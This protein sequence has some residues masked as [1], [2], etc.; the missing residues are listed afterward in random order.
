MRSEADRAGSSRFI[1]ASIFRV[2][3]NVPAWGSEYTGQAVAVVCRRGHKL[4]QGL[5]AWLRHS[6]ARAEYLEDG[7][8][9]WA[10]AGSLLVQT[11]PMPAR[12]MQ[13]Q[14]VWVARALLKIDRIACP[15]LIRRFIDPYAVFLFVMASEVPSVAERFGATPFDLESIFWSHRGEAW[16]FDV[17]LDEFGLQSD[18]LLRLAAIVRGAD[19]AKLEKVPQTAGLL[20]ASLGLSRIYRDGLGQLDATMGLY[21]AFYRWVRDTTGETDNWPAAGARP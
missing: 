13:G 8:E 21:D 1:P 5:A 14:T 2:S 10:K 19:T 3:D 12:N 9:A 18:A 20:A 4:S 15:W 7:F 6:G 11:A 17:M 16:T